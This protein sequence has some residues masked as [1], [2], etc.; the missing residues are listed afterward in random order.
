[1][2]AFLQHII[3][4]LSVGSTYALLALGLT[5]VFSI[6]N[7]INFG[8]GI[9]LVWGAYSFLGL[10][11]IGV[12]FAGAVVLSIIGVSLL[13]VII[14]RVAFRP[15][16]N[17]PQ[18]TLLITSFAVLLIVQYAAIVAWGEK[19]RIIN[20][21][22][23]FTEVINIGS[24]RV[25]LLE[26]ITIGVAAG[27]VLVYF[28]IL[29]RTSLGAQ[30]RGRGRAAQHDPPGGNQARR[31][32]DDRVCPLAR[33]R[34]HR[35]VALVREVWRG[36]ASER[37]RPDLESVHRD[38]PRWVGKHP[39]SSA[40]WA[41]ARRDRGVDERRSAGKRARL[42]ARDRLRDRH[43]DSRPE[44]GR[45]RRGE[46]EASMKLPVTFQRDRVPGL[47]GLGGALVAQ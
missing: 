5:L 25:P 29:N 6:M 4:A 15:F 40:R 37:S 26:V 11:E 7:L 46:G 14:G 22:G 31:G 45:H 18:I 36:H 27:V 39:W 16:I 43:R 20:Y 19:P 33:N 34:R 2:T 47:A 3:D 12:P 1:M 42:R 10:T 21:P 35:R 32:A 23:A 44:T 8:Y 38:R 9:L 30:V 41:G 17:A 28:V 24:L 13:N